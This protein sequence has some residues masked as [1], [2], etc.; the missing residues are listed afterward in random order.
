MFAVLHSSKPIDGGDWLAFSGSL[1][2]TTATLCVGIAAWQGL[3]SQMRIQQVQINCE[4]MLRR[5]DEIN[6]RL[7][8]MQTRTRAYEIFGLY[9]PESST[10]AELS[11]NIKRTFRALGHVV[12]DDFDYMAQFLKETSIQR[13]GGF[14]PKAD[15]GLQILTYFDMLIDFKNLSPRDWDDEMNT[16]FLQTVKYFGEQLKQETDE[17][18]D[19]LAERDQLD[20]DIKV[21]RQI[22][23]EFRI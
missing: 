12:G 6:A 3:R 17:F 19:L 9:I 8:D 2:A 18:D 23:R 5:R 22:I 11:R 14:V 16:H 1:L 20:I 15:P 4:F 13:R 21:A 10:P 7:P